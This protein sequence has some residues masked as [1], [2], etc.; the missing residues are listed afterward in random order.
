MVSSPIFHSTDEKCPEMW[1]NLALTARFAELG[2]E[3]MSPGSSYLDFSFSCYSTLT[4]I[5]PRK[6]NQLTYI[7][8]QSGPYQMRESVEQKRRWAISGRLLIFLPLRAS[9]IET[10]L[11][12]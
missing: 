3:L 8:G 6:R 4:S 7:P 2:L 10:S 1:N 9:P 12:D 11:L 5:L